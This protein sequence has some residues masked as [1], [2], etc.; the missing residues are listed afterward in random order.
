M[1]NKIDQ[2]TLLRS[3]GFEVSDV[4]AMLGMTENHVNVAAHAGR[5]KQEKKKAKN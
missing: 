1:E 2:V 5:K 4:A 3:A